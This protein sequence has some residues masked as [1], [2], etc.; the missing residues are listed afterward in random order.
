M[1][2]WKPNPPPSFEELP[3]I[4]ESRISSLSAEVDRQSAAIVRGAS[5]PEAR[6]CRV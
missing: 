4:L 6:P 2:R 3:M 1:F 5:C